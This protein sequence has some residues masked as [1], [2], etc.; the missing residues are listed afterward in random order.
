MVP[1]PRDGIAGF[2]GYPAYTTLDLASPFGAPVLYRAETGSTMDDARLLAEAGY[3]H[4]TVVMAGS[5]SAGRGRLPG[6]AWVAVPGESLL[7]TV[8]LHGAFPFPVPLAAG[9]A[10]ARALERT[11]P[12]LGRAEIK[13]PNDVMIGGRKVSGILCESSGGSVRVGIGVNLN[14]PSFPPELNGKATSL[15]LETGARV[16]PAGILLVV[17]R[18][19]KAVLA[20]P[21]ADRELSRRL[22]RAGKTVAFREGD[23]ET[24]PIV[25][26]LLVGLSP[27]GALLIM[28]EGETESREF[29]SGELLPAGA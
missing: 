21:D 1:E 13:W 27:A 26:G 15:L 16:E 28:P 2:S 4:G 25:R 18:E 14:Q 17:L 6:R 22:Y 8:I 11:Q 23:P 5:Q 20:G 12:D 7:F 19:L 24:G 3:P 9:L 10:V 29:H